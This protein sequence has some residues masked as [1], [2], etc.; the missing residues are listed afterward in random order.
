M[1]IDQLKFKSVQLG[2]LMILQMGNTDPN[3]TEAGKRI[4]GPDDIGTDGFSSS[5]LAEND[6]P[7]AH[8]GGG[9]GGF[10][11]RGGAALNDARVRVDCSVV[12][13]L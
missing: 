9:G 2:Y 8:G 12:L 13:S 1:G 4:R 11:R 3:N 10:M 6:F 5:R 7:A